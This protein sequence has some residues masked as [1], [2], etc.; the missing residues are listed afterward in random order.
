MVKQ[1]TE[2]QIDSAVEFWAKQVQHPR[3]RTLSSEERQMK[4]T[5]PVAM[6][7]M[8]ANMLVK[9]VSIDTIAK[10][11]KLLKES[12][13]DQRENM[14]SLNVDYAPD[15]FL[16]GVGSAAGIPGHNWPWKTNLWFEKGKVF[17][18]CGYGGPQEDVTLPN[19]TTEDKG[20]N[21][22]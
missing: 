18:S 22:V 13:L 19:L 1:L 9:E 5:E 21:N 14:I 8:M 11:K 17:A 3:F 4:E 7:E 20:K 2:N 6:A 16:S 15:T 12:L 10:F